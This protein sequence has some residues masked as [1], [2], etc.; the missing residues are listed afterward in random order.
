MT[1]DQIKDL[2]H[3][4]PFVPFR[5]HVAAEEKAYEIPHPDFAMLTHGGHNL[6]V[7]LEDA[8]AV[9]LISVPLITKLETNGSAAS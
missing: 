1:A 6:A 2:L 7:A 9:H 3:A 8:E 4:T 5:V